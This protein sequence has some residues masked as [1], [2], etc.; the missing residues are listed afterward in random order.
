MAQGSFDSLFYLIL[1]VT[2]VPAV[3]DCRGRQRA[4]RQKGEV[5][6]QVRPAG[7]PHGHS[8]RDPHLRRGVRGTTGMSTP[9]IR[10]GI[11]R[12]NIVAHLLD[13]PAPTRVRK[14]H[15]EEL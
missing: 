2:G 12:K 9:T 11:P 3:S 5:G 1:Y 10:Y 15:A 13:H 8:L 14:R 4:S 7:G 6:L